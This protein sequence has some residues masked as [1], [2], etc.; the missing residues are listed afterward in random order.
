MPNQWK[1]ETVMSAQ[2]VLQKIATLADW[3]PPLLVGLSFTV[4]GSFKLYGILRGIVGGH[5]K[6]LMTQFCGT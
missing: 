5:E 3:L 1:N 2:S 6:P 4:L